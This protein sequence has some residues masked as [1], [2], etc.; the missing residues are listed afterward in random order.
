M[1]LIVRY[2]NRSSEI[3]EMLLQCEQGTYTSAE[4]KGMMELQICLEL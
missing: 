2:V 3:Q 4:D 1:P